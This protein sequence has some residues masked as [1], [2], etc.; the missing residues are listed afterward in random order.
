M[1]GQVVD[2]SLETEVGSSF[3]NELGPSVCFTDS[4]SFGSFG[5]G[6][7]PWFKRLIREDIIHLHHRGIYA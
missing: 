3:S 6:E 4:G 2:A 7:K 1:D 5:N